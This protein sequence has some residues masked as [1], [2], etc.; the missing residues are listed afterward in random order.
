MMY[1]GYKQACEGFGD[2][3]DVA[4]LVDYRCDVYILRFTTYPCRWVSFSVNTLLMFSGVFYSNVG[5]VV[6]T[7]FPPV[8]PVSW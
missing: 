1:N 7:G 2:V 8:G 4:L 6:V 5:V 3:G